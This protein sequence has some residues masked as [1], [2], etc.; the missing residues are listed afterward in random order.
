MAN[1]QKDSDRIKKQTHLFVPANVVA[2]PAIQNQ[3]GECRL[4]YVNSL[5]TIAH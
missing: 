1:K 3:P 4:D 2:Y 5:E